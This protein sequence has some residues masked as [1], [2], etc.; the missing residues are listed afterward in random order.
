LVAVY[1]ALKAEDGKMGEPKPIASLSG[2]LLARKGAARPAM[3]RPS[4]DGSSSN[5]SV[6][7][8]DL[9][10]NDMGYDVNPDQNTPMDYEHDTGRN[11]LAN[12]VPEASSFVRE[13]QEMIA[14]QLE[15]Q[16]E[17]GF[18]SLPL[19]AMPVSDD[20]ADNQP[21]ASQSVPEFEPV[22]VVAP[23]VALVATVRP[24]QTAVAKAPRAAA[25]SK[26]K[27]AFTLR[28]DGERHLKLRL[29]CA[30]GNRSAQMLVTD[31]LDAF[32]DNMP[33]IA[34]LAARVPARK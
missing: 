7:H 8:D 3:R 21:Q 1:L 20:D 14:R 32:L 5:I 30:V 12:A 16:A 22:A 27:A 31:A 10:W 26:G 11:P 2:L 29:A 9:G 34:Q 6:L 18:E 25:G 24:I 23:P 17:V 33:E 15:A 4:A 19:T 28:L 13:Q